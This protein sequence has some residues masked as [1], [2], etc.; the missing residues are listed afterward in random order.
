MFKGEVAV[1]KC[2]LRAAEIGMILGRP[3][4]ECRYDALLDTG[5]GVLRA[6][7]KYVDTWRIQKGAVQV[8]L[9]RGNRRSYTAQE[10]KVVLAYVPEIDRILWIGP[11]IIDGK[12]GLSFRLVAARNNN[13]KLV[14][15][16]ADYLW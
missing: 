15:S 12:T 10:V 4:L 16:A 6:Q 3:F 11:D 7:V 14:R 9:R 1:A 13:R 5:K 8:S 2:L